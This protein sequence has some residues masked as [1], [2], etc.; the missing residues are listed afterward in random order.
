[1]GTVFFA[2][3]RVCDRIRIMKRGEISKKERFLLAA[4]D[5]QLLEK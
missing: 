4:Y 3:D 1:M 2:K 5:L